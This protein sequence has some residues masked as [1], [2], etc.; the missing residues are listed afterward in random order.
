M[1]KAF[2]IDNVLVEVT[3]F[4]VSPVADTACLST[5]SNERVFFDH[6]VFHILLV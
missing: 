6:V 3:G 5:A 2:T 1:R 4:A